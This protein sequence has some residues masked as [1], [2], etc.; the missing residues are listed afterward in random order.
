M[1][2]YLQNEFVRK[3]KFCLYLVC[4][5]PIFL[6]MFQSRKQKLKIKL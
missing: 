1:L 6:Q 5:V 4:Y 3:L 2:T